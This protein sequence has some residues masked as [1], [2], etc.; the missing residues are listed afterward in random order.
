MTPIGLWAKANWLCR[1]MRKHRMERKQ[2][3]QAESHFT[4]QNT[5]AVK[6]IEQLIKGKHQHHWQHSLSV[7]STS[8]SL[9]LFLC[10]S[11]TVQIL[12]FLFLF[13]RFGDSILSNGHFETISMDKAFCNTKTENKNHDRWH[14]WYKIETPIIRCGRIV[15]KFLIR[16][17]NWNSSYPFSFLGVFHPIHSSTTRVI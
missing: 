5:W 6:Q 3:R 15:S 16:N 4:M 17:W 12:I 13:F 10:P 11:F 7:F 1:Y 2:N 8:L 14:S 9:P